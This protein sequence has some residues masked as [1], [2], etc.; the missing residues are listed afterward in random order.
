MG[1]C[2]SKSSSDRPSTG[3]TEAK[4]N[5]D[6]KVILLGAGESGKS[7]FVKQLKSIYKIPM[8]DQDV[9][10]YRLTLH[11]NTLV[12]MNVLVTQVEKYGLSLSSEDKELAKT[13][14]SISED[15]ALK[16]LKPEEGAAVAKLWKADAIRK[17]FEKRSEFWILD[18]A[19]YYFDNVER[20]VTSD[21]TPSEEDCVMARV[22]T[23]GINETKIADGN[24]SFTV[25]DVAGQKSERK[26]WPNAFDNVKAV[27]FVVA[28]SGY[29]QVMFED[30]TQ[31]RMQEELKLFEV[32][33]NNPLFEECPVFLFLNKKDLFEK[34]TQEVPLT[35]CFKEYHGSSNVQDAIQYV[36]EQFEKK[37]EKKDRLTS[38]VISARYK[39]DVKWSWEEVS[40]IIQNGGKKKKK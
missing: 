4:G 7:T 22:R 16:L 36:Q 11:N 1:S 20:F 2:L 26:K 31:N 23:T 9:Q 5:K 29:H 33:A 27:V 38:F 18:S 32:I 6:Y 39:K 12:C 19:E 15:G 28:L 13:I 30:S 14:T 40:E 10:T 25:V 35:T 8:T 3:N 24:A 21:F 17:V 37:M 34:M